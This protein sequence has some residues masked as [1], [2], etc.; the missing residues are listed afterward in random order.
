MSLN[1]KK[2]TENLLSPGWSKY[3]KTCLYETHDITE[4]LQEGPNAVGLA[5]GKGMYHTERRNRFSKFQGSFGPMRAFGQIELEYEDGSR[6]V[7]PTDE[8]WR[9]SRGPV[10]YND[11]YGGEDFDA[12]LL[13]D[14][15][16]PRRF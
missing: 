13:E 7:V 4:M 14:R 12:R 1:G 11:V 8:S 10:T 5:L 6:E 16:E 2:S 3:N 15:M 9:V